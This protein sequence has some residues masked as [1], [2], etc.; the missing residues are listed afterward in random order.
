MDSRNISV[1]RH[2]RASHFRAS[3][4]FSELTSFAELEQRISDLPTPQERGDA[5]EVF[6]E[7]YLTTQ[8]VNQRATDASAVLP[9]TIPSTCT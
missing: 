4:L 9:P 3:G 8:K 2:G 7:A 6:A 5:F 1:A